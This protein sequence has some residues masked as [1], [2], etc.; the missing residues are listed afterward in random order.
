[1]TPRSCT[2]SL[3]ALA[4]LLAAAGCSTGQNLPLPDIS[5]DDGGGSEGLTDGD[6]TGEAGDAD[7]DIAADTDTPD[8]AD[9]DTDADTDTPDGADADAADDG[10]T[11]TC[12]SALD[13]NDFVDCTSDTCDAEFGV[14]V[15]EPIDG[16]CDDGNACTTGERC[17][18]VAG[19]VT[20]TPDPCDDGIDCTR[21]AC[22]PL[23]G[24]C[25]HT[26]NHA[27]C[28]PP[29]LCDPDVGGCADPPPCLTDADCADGDLCNGIETCDPATGCRA[30]RIVECNDGVVCTLDECDPGTGGCIATPDDAACDNRN[31][32]DGVETCDPA[33]GCQRGTPV[34]CSDGVTCTDDLCDSATGGCSHTP[35]PTR[36]DDA[37]FCNGPEVCDPA[38]G[39]VSGAAPAC[40]DGIP[41]TLDHCDVATDSC[42]SSA[43]DASCNDGQF[44]NGPEVCNPATGCLAGTPPVCDD[45][46]GCTSDSCDAAGAGGAGA[47]TAASPDRDGDTYGDQSCTGSDCNDTNLAIH[48]GA[49]EVCNSLDDD[50]NGATDET[51]A[52]VPGSAQ[53]CT[54][55]A[56]SGSQTCSGSCTW[57]ACTVSGAEVCNG[58]DDNCNGLSD[59]G[60][61]CVLGATQ[62]C[63]VG[64]C[65]GTQS[66]GAGCSWG[67]CNVTAT[68]VCN[69]ADDN[70]N[71]STDEGF[72]CIAG[73]TQSCTVGSCSGTQTC[74]FSCAWGSCT[75]TASESCNGIDDN[76]NGATDEVF[77][78]RLGATQGCTTA[79]GT[80][81]SQSCQAGSCTW[82]SCCA[83]AEIC[84]NGCDDNCAG[85]VD[86]GCGCTGGEACSCTLT[87]AGTGGTYSGSTAGHVN[88][89]TAACA[90]S[91]ASPD[92]VYA[93]T[94]ACSGNWTISTVGSSY[95]T[96]LHVH[97]GGCPGSEI[98]CDDDAGGSL[99]SLLTLA[100]TGGTTYYIVVDGFGSG[101]SGNYVLNVGG[102]VCGGATPGD[103]CAGASGAIT[104]SGSFAGDTCS[105]A[106]DYTGSCAGGGPDLV[107]R[108]T[109]STTRTVRA[110]TV[111]GASW[112]TVLYVHS[113]SCPGTEVACSDDFSGVQSQVDF[114]ATAGVTYY[115]FVDGF[116]SACGAYTMTITYL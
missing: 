66:C 32:C 97:S 11:V 29:Q 33:A 77:A 89:Y 109:S 53:A 64:S 93:F 111:G 49:S 9:A 113:G 78:C 2:A 18:P 5:W 116:G 72:S 36:C 76:C 40:D 3:V 110:S 73:R 28:T 38:V 13:C 67:A 50:C 1:M 112:D 100:L 58:V 70:C 90:A 75:V 106:A 30:G 37:R 98:A 22:D 86:E 46:L 44:C 81:G 27:A 103:Q 20:G 83:P 92:L 65:P 96:A 62:P 94:P 57:G 23:T 24:G 45:G 4:A 69:G 80:G 91:A 17:D 35:N 102:V 115:V 104:A 99:T 108:L 42:T 74:S 56:C 60:Y 10:T 68:E 15:N 51:Y 39:C 26:A 101:A 82:G 54:V 87:V 48:P 88:D 71:G 105:R 85:G 79:C 14:C 52:C 43:D 61:S 6:E 55:G 34:N 19:C 21:D 8:G 63:W 107:Y 16:I 114:T 59:E 95:D 47:C 41:C 25:T 84:G 12:T 31:L 7:A